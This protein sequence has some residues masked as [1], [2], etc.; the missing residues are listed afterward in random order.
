MSGI[1]HR[2]F[3]ILAQFTAPALVVTAILTAALALTRLKAAAL[4]GASACIALLIAVTPQWFPGEPKPGASA[5][6]VRLY[7]ANLYYLND[8]VAAI[9]A[10]I[11]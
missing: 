7:S 8:D 4:H 3:D 6:I 2:W 10:S 9:R 11:R 5:P 1:G